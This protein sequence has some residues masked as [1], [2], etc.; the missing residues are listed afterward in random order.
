MWISAWQLNQNEPE[1]KKNTVL[2]P[3]NGFIVTVWI[4]FLCY[5]YLLNG[6]VYSGEN[7]ESVEGKFTKNGQPWHG[8]LVDVVAGL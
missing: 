8:S 3:Y 6:N 2:L 1:V 5:T 4:F 7:V